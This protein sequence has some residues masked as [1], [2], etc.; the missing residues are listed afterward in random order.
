MGQ[1][2]DENRTLAETFARAW[3]VASVLPRR[4]LTMLSADALDAGYQGEP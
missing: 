2:R 1:R 3:E 4:E